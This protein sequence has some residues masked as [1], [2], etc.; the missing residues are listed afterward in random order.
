MNVIVA[1]T[2]VGLRG[3]PMAIGNQRVICAVDNGDEA[4]QQLN[5]G[6]GAVEGDGIGKPTACYG[7]VFPTPEIASLPATMLA[8]LI[9]TILAVTIFRK[10]R[11]MPRVIAQGA[12]L[13]G[14]RGHCQLINLRPD[15]L[16]DKSQYF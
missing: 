5:I 16:Q 2:A 6:C 9:E 3:P 7:F 10:L 11:N 1:G 13:F 12:S 4:V 15:E 14:I 8:P